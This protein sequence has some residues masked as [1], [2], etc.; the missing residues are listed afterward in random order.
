MDGRVHCQKKW[1]KG[2]QKRRRG[3]NFRRP[4]M[5]SYATSRR[6]FE[7]GKVTKASICTLSGTGR[8]EIRNFDCGP[9][10]TE[11]RNICL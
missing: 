6:T 2:D 9:G 3:S 11:V 1:E 10:G 8:A 4:F 5:T 7:A